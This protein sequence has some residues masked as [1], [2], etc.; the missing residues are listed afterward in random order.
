MTAEE[1]DNK[2]VREF[3][4]TLKAIEKDP[5]KEVYSWQFDTV[6]KG[7]DGPLKFV[8]SVYYE[9]HAPYGMERDDPNYY[10]GSSIQPMIEQFEQEVLPV[11]VDSQ[12][13]SLDKTYSMDPHSYNKTYGYKL[14]FFP[15][16]LERKHPTPVQ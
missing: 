9:I 7:F 5:S 8:L 1:E 14:V 10:E 13:I 6:R 3:Y 12:I 2:K 4:E 11:L 15:E 16:A